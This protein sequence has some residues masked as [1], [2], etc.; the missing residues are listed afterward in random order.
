MPELPLLAVEKPQMIGSIPFDS[1]LLQ[2]TQ[3]AEDLTKYI[4]RLRM[5]AVLTIDAPWGEGK[6]WFGKNWSAKLQAGGHKTVFIDAFEQDYMEDPFMLITSELIEMLHDEKEIQ[7]T[8]KDKATQVSKA[9]L[10][11][12]GKMSIK[13]LTKLLLGEVDLGSEVEKAME[14]AG[15]DSADLLSGWIQNKFDSY[16][17]DKQT[18]HAFK[19][20]LKKYAALQE[21]PIVIF[22]DE[23]DRCRPAFAVNILERIKHFFDVP[24]VVFV[25]LVNKVQ[26]E[27]A[28]KGV[29]GTD[30][31]AS[32]YLGKFIN[33]F[34]RLP[35]HKFEDFNSEK[36][37]ERFVRTTFLK[38]KFPDN[39][40][41]RNIIKLITTLVVAFDLSLRDIE[42]V[43]ALYAFAYPVPRL[44]E[45][46]VYIIVLKQKDSTLFQQLVDGNKKAH[47]DMKNKLD[48]ILEL[49]EKRGGNKHMFTI[50]KEWHEAYVNGFE[51]IGENFKKI[52]GFVSESEYDITPKQVLPWFAKQ[53]DL[54]IER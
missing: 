16:E 17:Q 44:G 6:T 30:T 41:A 12:S 5:G 34:F 14:S 23:L 7:K 50:F 18:I 45:I 36:H 29:Y 19:E 9:T 10:S 33:F 25:L 48:L 11:F 43:I 1:D 51:P 35:K 39:S 13:A 4:D 52:Y 40:S 32:A 2:R 20:E 15:D 49:E 3:L 38:Y 24:N 31:D 26:L 53:I 42:K 8:F 28:I 47:D 21:K 54:E 46:L 37:I 22:I 27:N